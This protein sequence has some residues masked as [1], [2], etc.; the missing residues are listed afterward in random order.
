MLPKECM[1]SIIAASNFCLV[2]LRGTEIFGT[3]IPSNIFELMAMNIPII[4]GVKGEA[5]EIVLRGKAGVVMEPDDP[6]SLLSCIEKIQTAGKESFKGRDYV[7]LYYDRDKL[8]RDMVEIV[9][10][11]YGGEIV[12]EET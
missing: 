9:E 1:P 7:S 2:H 8:A 5:Q 6:Q 3:V 12:L 4:M 11:V 10:R